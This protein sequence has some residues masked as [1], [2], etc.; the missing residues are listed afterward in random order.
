MLEGGGSNE[1]KIDLHVSKNR[2]FYTIV[3]DWMEPPPFQEAPRCD[4]CKCS[5]NAFRRR[6]PISIS[7][8]LSHIYIYLFMYI[9]I[10]GNKWNLMNL[11]VPI[12]PIN[13]LGPIKL[14]NLYFQSRTKRLCWCHYLVFT[15]KV[16]HASLGSQS[17]VLY[18]L[19]SSKFDIDGQG[20]SFVMI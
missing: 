19:L 10:Y 9:Y 6:V 8:S 20:A 11:W 12:W 5:F 15:A 1:L 18:L 7:L 14:I 17:F 3:C 2:S 16:L 13:T 4:V